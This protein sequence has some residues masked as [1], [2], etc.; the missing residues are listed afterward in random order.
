M[1]TKIVCTLGPA[2]DDENVLREMIRAGMDVARINFS[3]GT[4]EQHAR[5]I[6]I[7]RRVVAEENALV[8][9]MGDLQGPK[10]RVGD[11]PDA[12]VELVR[13]ATVTFSAHDAFSQNSGNLIIPLPHEDLIS[14]LAP[15]QRILI[16]DGAMELRV[17]QAP[18]G[19]KVMAQV[20]AGGLLTSHKGVAAPGARL[21][22]SS[23][24]VKDRAD[25]Q[26]A[27]EHKLDALA[28]S[29]VRQAAD[30][31]ELRELVRGLGGDPLIVAKIEKPEAVGDLANILREVDVVMVA[32][33][34]LGVEAPAEEVPFYQKTI[35]RSCLRAGVP[36]ITATQML[37][38]MIHTP[39]PTRA[40]ASDVANAVLDGT[41]AVML[42]AET[43]TGEYPVLAVEAI[44]RIA[45]RAEVEC[46][47]RAL[48]ELDAP[49]HDMPQPDPT[50]QS[51]T[52]AAAHMARDIGAKAIVC[53][54]ASGYTARMV[55]RHRPGTPI[56]ALTPD[57]RTYQ[58]T[59][60][61]WDVRAVM[62]PHFADLDG[63]FQAA[64]K[65]AQE[66]G[67]ATA[68]DRI[69]VTAGIPVGAG[70]GKTNLIK[71]HTV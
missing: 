60:F 34:D 37:Q 26:F 40:E 31:R 62:A 30:V 2:S 48:L 50:T 25:A 68:G 12:G 58:F 32:R 5:R 1:R 20:I 13:N 54:T 29:F 52:H 38:S 47:E 17:T 69:V 9:I 7:V 67:Y 18:A 23:I 15:D 22:V 43:A 21:V 51:I 46:C 61:I 42:S 70:A 64:A 27:V 65:L 4:H 41:D 19:G 63:M 36:V 24:T 6:D 59:A 11:V 49:D 35:I 39:S 10:F 57:A 56:L 53:T 33:G 66:A 14:I 28:L 8:A 44:A 3:H 55:A 16:D 45:S 71:V